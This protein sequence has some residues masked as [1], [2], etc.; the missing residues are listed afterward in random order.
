[1]SCSN[2]GLLDRYEPCSDRTD[3]PSAKHEVDELLAQVR[4]PASAPE[5]WEIRP[6][7]SCRRGVDLP[8]LSASPSPVD[9]AGVTMPASDPSPRPPGQH[10]FD[11][12]LER[13]TL[14]S[15][16][17]SIGA[18]CIGR[19]G[20]IQEILAVLAHRHFG[21]GYTSLRPTPARTSRGATP[22]GSPWDR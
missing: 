17:P 22:P 6:P 21:G 13:S 5:R 3:W 7:R 4:M 19:H 20:F 1:M 10:G 15:R 18:V 8:T 2:D 12:V 16:C 9:V 14:P 11:V